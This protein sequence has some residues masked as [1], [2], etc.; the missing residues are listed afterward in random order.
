MTDIILEIKDKLP[1]N[2]LIRPLMHGLWSITLKKYT[3]K[4]YCSVDHS[5]LFEL[6]MEDEGRYN[7]VTASM[8]FMF[9]FV[10]VKESFLITSEISDYKIASRLFTKCLLEVEDEYREASIVHND[11]RKYPIYQLFENA[12]VHDPDMGSEDTENSWKGFTLNISDYIS[13]RHNIEVKYNGELI[14]YFR[15]NIEIIMAEMVAGT[16]NEILYSGLPIE[17]IKSAKVSPN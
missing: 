1:T 12:L 9:T 3:G 16:A 11:I 7:F 4:N 15:Y 14:Y 6:N 17:R 10:M 5:I 8:T 2:S 13:H